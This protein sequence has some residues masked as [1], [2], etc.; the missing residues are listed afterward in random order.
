MNRTGIV[1]DQRFLEHRPGE[2]HP[3]SPRRLEV[4]Y[5]MLDEPEMEGRFRAVP[6]RDAETEELCQIHSP[7]YVRMVQG[8][9]G[10]SY[11]AL[12]PDTATSPGSYQAALLAAGGL[13]EAISMV[14]SGDLDNAFALVRPPGHHAEYARAMGF[15][16]FNNIAIGARYAQ[17][18]HDIERVL[19][20]DWDLHHGNGT[21]HAFE[22]DPSVLYFSTHQ[23]PYY[24]GSGAVQQVGRGKGEGYTVNVPLSPGHG[25]K[26]YLAIFEKILKPIALEFKP[27]L[28]LVSAGF[29]I[30]ENDPLGGMR[31]SPGGFGA[32]TRCLMEMADACC[33]GRLVI[34]LEGGYHLQGLRDSVRAVLNVLTGSS[35]SHMTQGEDVGMA[36]KTIEQTI[37][38]HRQYW[39]SLRA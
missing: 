5:D 7:E 37:Q 13:C 3:E 32:L 8:T 1:R 25:D 10:R 27:G 28:V 33:G 21:Q 4:L 15:C 39:S 24:P 36:G 16:L 12:D 11:V 30:Y 2:G 20:V 9:Q 35:D 26:E 38:F 19:V 23:Y 34:T 22:E 14:L 18:S 29:D 17:Q 6:V 31:V